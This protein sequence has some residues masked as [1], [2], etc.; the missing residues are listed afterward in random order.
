VEVLHVRQRERA[1]AVSCAAEPG[2]SPAPGKDQRADGGG[3]KTG[4]A[5][6]CSLIT[7]R[8]AA[9][10]AHAIPDLLA[11]IF[12]AYCSGIWVEFHTPA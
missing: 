8:P 10:A 11:T 9:A 3:M 2:I 7:S 4:S 1:V 12:S 5:I 6:T